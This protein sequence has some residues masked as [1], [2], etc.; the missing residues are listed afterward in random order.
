M[1]E[2]PASD[3]PATSCSLPATVV[4]DVEAYHHRGP[5]PN[6]LACQSI[7]AGPRSRVPRASERKR[8]RSDSLKTR[9]S[10][11]HR[12]FVES[13][14]SHRTML[15]HSDI[16]PF[17]H[18]LSTFPSLGTTRTHFVFFRYPPCLAVGSHMPSLAS[19]TSAFSQKSKGFIRSCDIGPR[20]DSKGDLLSHL[21]TTVPFLI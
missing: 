10:R 15:R 14:S 9:P 20:H 5:R 19:S 12:G 11:K 18:V 3:S 21:R 1:N 8:L 2:H 17:D 7:T 13:H 4:A 6:L 16:F